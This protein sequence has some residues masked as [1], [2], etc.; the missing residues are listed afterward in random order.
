MSIEALLFP[1]HPIRAQSPERAPGYGSEQMLGPREPLS[2]GRYKQ[3][4]DHTM[5]MGVAPG[6]NAV[7][8]SIQV[9]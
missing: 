1:P 5:V 8:P 4:Q 9:G 2:G 6:V 3:R 7:L